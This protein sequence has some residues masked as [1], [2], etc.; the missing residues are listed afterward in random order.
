MQP[1]LVGEFHLRGLF[2]RKEGGLQ[3]SRIPGNSQQGG[4]HCPIAVTLDPKVGPGGQELS[5]RD[6]REHLHLEHL[7]RVALFAS[8]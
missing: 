6:R 3:D 7:L 5:L 2:M 1:D 4:K 8:L